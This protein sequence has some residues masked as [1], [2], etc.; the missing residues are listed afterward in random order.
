MRTTLL[1]ISQIPFRLGLL[2][3]PLFLSTALEH[4][5]SSV[6]TLATVLLVRKLP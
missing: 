5:T 1:A 6:A 3:T 2:E 4:A